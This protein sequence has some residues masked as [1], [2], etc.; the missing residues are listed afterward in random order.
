M[1]VC[2]RESRLGP[3][4][5]QLRVVWDRQWE[6]GGKKKCNVY[7]HSDTG[8]D[9]FWIFYVLWLHPVW[10]LGP[11][12]LTAAILVSSGVPPTGAVPSH[13]RLLGFSRFLLDLWISVHIVLKI[14]FY[15]ICIVTTLS[16]QWN[17]WE[18]TPWRV[19]F[20]L[21]LTPAHF[22]EKHGRKYSDSTVC[23]WSTEL[24]EP[25]AVSA[26]EGGWVGAVGGLAMC[27]EAEKAAVTEV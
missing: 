8:T 16:N 5:W 1:C 21:R 17:T 4:L 10:Y 6:D 12:G 26:A 3:S 18:E 15:V 20:P 2:V 13:N 14:T 11:P 27:C 22:L 25:K 9:S 24:G 23:I 19:L 7:I